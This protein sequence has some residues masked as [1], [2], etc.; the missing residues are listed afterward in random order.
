MIE[1]CYR[2]LALQTSSSTKLAF[3]KHKISDID[4]SNRIEMD[5]LLGRR[6]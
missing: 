5:F 1:Y 6:Y 3:L 2:P 4:L